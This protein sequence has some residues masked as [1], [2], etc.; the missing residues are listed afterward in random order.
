MSKTLINIQNGYILIQKEG[1]NLKKTRIF[2]AA[3]ALFMLIAVSASAELDLKG[4][5]DTE[6]SALISQAQ[7]ELNS[8]RAASGEEQIV[9]YNANGIYWYITDY[10][11]SDWTSYLTINSIVENK[12]DKNVTLSIDTLSVNGW[13][14]STFVYAQVSAGKKAKQEI[15]FDLSDASVEKA[16]EI[17][18]MEAAIQVLNSDSYK[19]IDEVTVEFAPAF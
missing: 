1:I 15:A 8:R 9:L 7:Q 19:T 4:M 14:V 5:S 3:L 6:L 2:L 16:S 11:K 18:T 10:E 13:D 12:S 17:T